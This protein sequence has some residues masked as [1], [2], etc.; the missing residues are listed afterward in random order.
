MSFAPTFEE[1]QLLAD[2]FRRAGSQLSER[3]RAAELAIG[4]SFLAAVAALWAISPPSG[5]RVGPALLCMAVLALAT[6]I[7]FDT[8]FGFTVPTQL[9][10]VPLVFAVPLAVVPIAVVIALAVARTRDVVTGAT[11]PS[12]LLLTPGNAWFA[13]GPPLVFALA[14]T[15]PARAGAW[16]L[17][18]ALAAQFVTDF[19]AS[20]IRYSVGRGATFTSQL[21]DTWV[22]AIDAA[23][24][25]IALLAAKDVNSS[26]E[27]VLALVP[28]LG[29]LAMFAGE[30]QKRI[31]SLLEL[32]D[33]Y[34]GTALVLGDVVEADDG[35]TGEHC[36]N[37]VALCLDVADSLELTGG[38]TRNLEFAALLH[39]V[40]KIAIPKVVMNKPGKLTADEWAIMKTHTIEGQKMLNRVGGFMRE[41]GQIVRSHHE[42]WDGTGY[43]D[44]LAGEAIPLEAR[45]IAAC[46]AWNAMRTDRVYRPALK[47]EDALAE[48]HAG[49][50]GQFD[51]RVVSVLAGLVGLR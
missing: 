1:Q 35:Y 47:Y 14:N 42:R 38:Q 43:P 8:P 46:D 36:K 6:A 18:T 26:P 32:N 39:D 11:R 51:P 3:E 37:V 2:S 33:A 7:K 29:I 27:A 30:R 23:L 13:I 19:T 17:V 41:V 44:R 34:R 5:L 21:R 20:S 24:S 22:Y 25:C 4:I 16:L 50:G 28:L 15:T 45:I 12:R 10:F 9:G 49:S 40:G 31:R 48:L